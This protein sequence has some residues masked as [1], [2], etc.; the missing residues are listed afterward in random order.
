M[1]IFTFYNCVL[2][3]FLL[4]CNLNEFFWGELHPKGSL[5]SS[6]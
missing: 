6:P 3:K 1:N 4:I 2:L 5:R